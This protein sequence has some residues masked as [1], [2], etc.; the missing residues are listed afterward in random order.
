MSFDVVIFDWDGTLVDSVDHIAASLEQ[1]AGDLGYPSA[2]AKSSGI[3]WAWA[4]RRP[5]STC[6]RGF[7]SVKLPSSGRRTPSISSVVIRR[8]KTFSRD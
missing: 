5:L 2:V 7:P 4:C 8:R 1:A 3:L 6:I